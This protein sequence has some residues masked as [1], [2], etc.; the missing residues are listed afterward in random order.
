MAEYLRN[1]WYMAGWESE[2]EGDALLSR[3]LLDRPMLIYRRAD[4]DGYVMMEDRCAHRFAPLR[5]GRREGDTIVCGYHGL[6]YDRTGACVR[7]PF[8]K[9]IPDRAKVAVVPVS[10]KCGILWFWPGDPSLA[11]LGN[12][13]DFSCLAPNARHSR[14]V[15]AANYQ[16]ITDNLMDLSHIE[17]V[18]VGTFGGAGV[19][20]Q[21][22]HEVKPDGDAI[23]SNWWMPNI[24]PPPWAAGMSPAPKLDHWLN[25]RWNAPATMMLETGICP[26]DSV[27]RTVP[28]PMPSE[29]DCHIL[30]PET[31]FSTHYFYTSSEMQELA[32]VEKAYYDE[33]KPILEAV[34][35]SMGDTDFWGKQPVI[36]SVDA[37]AI[38]VRRRLAKLILDERGA[39]NPASAEQLED[40]SSVSP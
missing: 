30:T 35:R 14:L 24:D 21:G 7:N 8:S 36:L 3:K 6:T 34:Q 28:M 23:W 9:Q 33:D 4:G 38:R 2:I 16:L 26:A 18:H 11:D 39:T 19:I 40:L 15:V 29:R 37:A 20:F 31:E 17:F 13:P 10:A 22:E 32:S 25:M 1:A 27:A 12:I 5:L